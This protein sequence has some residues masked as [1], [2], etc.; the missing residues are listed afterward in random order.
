MSGRAVLLGHWFAWECPC[1]PCSCCSG[2]DSRIP[3]SSQELTCIAAR[4]VTCPCAWACVCLG[5]AGCMPVA[6]FHNLLNRTLNYAKLA[7]GDHC[8]ICDSLIV[9]AASTIDIFSLSW[10]RS[11]HWTWS[12]ADKNNFWC[13]CSLYAV[14]R[15]AVKIF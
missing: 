14:C 4:R 2:Q 11:C 5:G 7:S 9:E 1:Q 6:A 12:H 15:S 3:C 8:G 13:C 10:W